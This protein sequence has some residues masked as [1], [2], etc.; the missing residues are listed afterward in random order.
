MLCEGNRVINIT[1]EKANQKP[2]CVTL[3]LI[4][5]IKP[6][7]LGIGEG[8]NGYYTINPYNFDKFSWDLKGNIYL[9]GKT[10]FYYENSKI[11]VNEEMDNNITDYA[12]G[13]IFTLVTL[14]STI[15]VTVKKLRRNM[16]GGQGDKKFYGDSL[17]D[18]GTKTLEQ[19]KN[20]GWMI[21]TG[22]LIGDSDRQIQ[23]KFYFDVS[24]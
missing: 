16:G 19:I 7:K 22:T 15:K 4:V 13:E 6:I 12:Y 11:A 14:E 5:K 23:L 21:D 1:V 8:T 18:C 24:E 20:A 17:Y 3:Y 9:N 10:V 2:K